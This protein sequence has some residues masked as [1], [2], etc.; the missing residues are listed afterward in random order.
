VLLTIGR[1]IKSC[2]IDLIQK[3]D[4]Y[5]AVCTTDNGTAVAVSQRTVE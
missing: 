2:V 5:F 3:T 4:T 1:R